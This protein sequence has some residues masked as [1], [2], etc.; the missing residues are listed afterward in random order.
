MSNV[1]DFVD[2]D[3]KLLPNI[4]EAVQKY[5][6]LTEETEDYVEALSIVYE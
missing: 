1:Q 5:S 3:V 4:L 6:R 2:I